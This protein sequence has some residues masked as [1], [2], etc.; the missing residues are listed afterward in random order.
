V[1][2]KYPQAE[3]TDEGGYIYRDNEADDPLLNEITFAVE[4][5]VVTDIRMTFYMP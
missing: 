5:G 3:Q 2:D 1:L 4:D